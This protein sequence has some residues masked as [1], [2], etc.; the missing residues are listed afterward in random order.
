MTGQLLPFA[1]PTPSRRWTVTLADGSVRT[2]EAHGFRC[3]HGALV[4]VLPAGCVAAY[5]PG[6]WAAV[7]QEP[8]T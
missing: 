2:V 1:Q 5:A 3:E 8:A 6:T 4:L 7:E